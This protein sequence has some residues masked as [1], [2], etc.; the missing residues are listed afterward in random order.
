MSPAA[1]IEPVAVRAQGLACAAGIGLQAVAAAVQSG[2]NA[3]QSNTFSRMPLPTSI[4]SIPGLDALALPDALAAWDCRA[5]RAAWAG[6]LADDFI[7]AA[8]GARQRHG[9]TRVG[10]VLGTS[11]STIGVSEAAY[12]ALAPDGGFA[13]P[14]RS[15]RLN[16]LHAVTLFVQEALALQGPC[17]TVSTACSSSAKAFAVAERWLRLDLADAVVVAGV[18]AL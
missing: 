15:E 12:A 8:H 9:A 3:L 7:T 17:M 16:N 11:A 2:G 18:D 13:P 14:V 10:L 5:T 4:G 1:Q 6:M